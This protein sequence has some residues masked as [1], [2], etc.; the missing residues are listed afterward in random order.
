MSLVPVVLDCF[1]ALAMT[2]GYSPDFRQLRRA[3]VQNLRLAT[4]PRVHTSICN[5]DTG[6][7]SGIIRAEAIRY[8]RAQAMGW[9]PP[10]NQE[11]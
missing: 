3:R 11:V 9:S 10:P 4:L 5:E 6:C 2:N 8:R 1:A 7:E